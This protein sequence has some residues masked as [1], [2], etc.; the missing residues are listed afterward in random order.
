ME[1]EGASADR[2]MRCRADDVRWQSRQMLARMPDLSSQICHYGGM[3][4]KWLH[5]GNKLLVDTDTGLYLI[6]IRCISVITKS[7]T[8][9]F[10]IKLS[11]SIK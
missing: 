7:K 6:P 3:A 11:Q 8:T 5:E 10:I 9:A 1:N 2:R 4:C